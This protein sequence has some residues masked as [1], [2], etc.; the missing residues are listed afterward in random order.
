MMPVARIMSLYR[1]HMGRKAVTVKAV[2][3]GLDVTASRT[4]RRV[5]LFVVN[6]NRTRSVRARLAVDGMRI[7]SGQVFEIADDPMR[8]MD[9]T[10]PDAFAPRQRALPKSAVWEFA[11]A[12]VTAVELR[13]EES[14]R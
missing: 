4:G 3:D 1:G 11:P 9:A 6:T 5:F 14:G 12:S 2:P 7:G 13:V 8:E 10:I